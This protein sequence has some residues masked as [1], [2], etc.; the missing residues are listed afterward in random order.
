MKKQK[1]LLKKVTM[2]I[3]VH[4]LFFRPWPGLIKHSEL[5]HG[6][7]NVIR[8]CRK[9]AREKGYVVSKHHGY[10]STASILYKIKSIPER[11]YVVIADSLARLGRNKEEVETFCN[12]V[13]SLGASVESLNYDLEVP[14]KMQIQ[15][16]ITGNEKDY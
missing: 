7:T 4:A 15:N 3:P 1:I 10:N 8:R 9:Y 13:L 16:K 11:K 12:E 2:R 14:A 6:S 5:G